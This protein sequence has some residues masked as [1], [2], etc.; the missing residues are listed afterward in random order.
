MKQDRWPFLLSLELS[1]ALWAV[2]LGFAYLVIA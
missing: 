2:I 1:L